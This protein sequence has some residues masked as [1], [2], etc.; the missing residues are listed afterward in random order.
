MQEQISFGVWLRKQRRALDL[1]RQA[2]ADQ[3]GCA[4]VTLRRIEAG[5]LKPSR[6]L[7]GILLDRLGT[8][9]TD[10]L[11]WISFARGL[12]DI[13]LSSAPPSNKPDTNLPAPLTSFIG[14]EKEQSEVIGLIAKRRLVTLTG[15]G[16]VGKTRLSIKVGEQV[17]RNYADGVWMVELAPILESLLVPRRTAIAIGLRDEPKRPVIDMLCDYLREKQMLIIFD[18]CEHLLDACAQLADALLKHSPGLKILATSREAL[19]IL[20]EAVYPVPSLQLP[21]VQKL[22]KN[23]RDCESV[24]LFEERAQLYRMDFS[25]TIDNAPSV[26]RICSR[27]DGIPLAIE[28]A[29]ARVNN[30]SPK[31]IEE[32]LQGTFSL[33]TTGNRTALPRHQT[34]RAA[35]DWSYDLLAPVEQALFQRLSIFVDGWTLEAAKFVCSDASIKSEAILD[36]LTQLINKSLVV[37]E[38]EEENERTRY[39]MLETIRQYANEKSVESGETDRLQ[40]KHL[41]FF[42]NLAEN[43]EP[44]V[45]RPEQIE[46]LCVLD[47]DYDNL[48][49]ALD[50][51][52]RKDT[53]K[54]A[55]RLCAALGYYWEIRGH[56]IEGA[57]S[58]ATALAMPVDNRDDTEKAARVRALIQDANLADD[59]DN[60]ERLINASDLALSLANECSDQRDIAI[61]RLYTGLALNRLGDYDKAIPYLAES[62][63]EFQ[64]LNDPYWEAYANMHLGGAILWSKS[65]NINPDTI[66]DHSLRNVELARKAGERGRLARVLIAYS[67]GLVRV[68]QAEK[69]KKHLIE[70]QKAIEEIGSNYD[71][72][73]I[74]LAEIEWLEGNPQRAKAI[75]TESHARLQLNGE[76][77]L[78]SSC[79]QKLGLL[80]I[81]EGDLEQAQI[82]L[83]DALSIAQDVGLDY[84]IAGLLILLSALFYLQGDKEKSRQNIRKSIPLVKKLNPVAKIDLLALLFISPYY[85]KSENGVLLLGALDISQ[86]KLPWRPHPLIKRYLVRAKANASN[87][88]GK[89]EFESAFAQGQKMSLDETL[90]LA[91]KTVGEM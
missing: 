81:E 47:N 90:D 49:L 67:S 85:E 69:A 3:V 66:I 17:L 53:A 11:K 7:A 78:S 37:A 46:W 4:E 55:L 1:T 28:L 52:L 30:L 20:G 18:N 80:S 75:I 24:R 56:W 60:L 63:I 8:P 34:L 13:P 87:S 71:G 33:L 32:R 68:G 36:L 9:E 45:I 58:L 21:E 91:L 72:I 89:K 48:R 43:A 19:G 26:V 84:S 61:A 51:A 76:K 25:L 22:V 44:H 65:T 40:D 86:K 73:Q 54:P 27:L 29:A 74:C 83:E 14:R 10:R 16:G 41:E 12:S 77:A 23:F 70:A 82:Y 2:F 42:L 35:I 38:A 57:K 15:S 62:V 59:L 5:T 6:E 39:R 31:I 79:L 50:W 88:L 64:R